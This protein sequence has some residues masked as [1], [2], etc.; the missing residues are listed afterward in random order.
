MQ[1]RRGRPRRRASDAAGAPGPVRAA[2]YL[3]VSTLDQASEGFGLD[4]QETVIRAYCT[5]QGWELIG[6]YTDAGLSGSTTD[7]P[8]LARLLGDARAGRFERIVVLKLDRLARSLKDMLR[9]YDELES[10]NVAVASVR[11]ALDTSTHYG[12]LFRNI[13]ASLAEFERDAIAERVSGGQIEKARRGGSL[14][15]FVPYGYIRTAG[16][17]ETDQEAAGIVRRIFRERA[18]GR[19][20][21]EIA[22]DLNMD[23]VPTARGASWKPGTIHGILSNP[24][25][26]GRPAWNKR[27]APITAEQPTWPVIVSEATFRGCQSATA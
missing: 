7:R 3:R 2:A 10:Y 8:E 23:R 27:S 4:A 17:I 24:A 15:G 26:T 11:E 18:S 20:L 21:A 5:A 1:Q 16:G 12:R 14:G 25:Y 19:T 22:T 13:L 9:L 6:L